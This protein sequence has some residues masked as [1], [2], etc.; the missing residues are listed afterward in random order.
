MLLKENTGC[1]QNI[2]GTHDQDLGV[3]GQGK[4]P[5]GSDI[6]VETRVEVSQAK[7]WGETG[8]QSLKS[9]EVKKN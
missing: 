2:I 6:L 8:A 7:R 5:G 9:L 3:G 1:C 4:F